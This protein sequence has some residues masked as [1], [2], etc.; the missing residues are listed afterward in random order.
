MCGDSQWKLA[1]HLEHPVEF[2][3]LIKQRSRS[4]TIS[5]HQLSR[6]SVQMVSYIPAALTTVQRDHLRTL[7]D[8][9][10]V[11][12][13]PKVWPDDPFLLE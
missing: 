4:S 11:I 3:A 10:S 5:A 7:S 9:A 13:L 2:F 12:A 8:Q 6:F 1:R